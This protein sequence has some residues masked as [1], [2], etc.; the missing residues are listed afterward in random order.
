MAEAGYSNVPVKHLPTPALLSLL[1]ACREDPLEQRRAT[2]ASGELTLFSAALV[3]GYQIGW[4]ELY[5]SDEDGGLWACPTRLRGGETGVLGEVG[6]V[7]MEVEIDLGD[8][9]RADRVF[10]R[11]WGA[12]ASGGVVDPTGELRAVSVWGAKLRGSAVEGG[13]LMAMAN[14][15][16]FHLGRSG[17]CVEAE[18]LDDTGEGLGAGG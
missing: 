16:S 3:E 15:T 12:E 5:L 11:Y 17:D 14:L 7:T 1:L 2:S 18:A 13:G 8:G 6:L 10:A 4:G 9:V